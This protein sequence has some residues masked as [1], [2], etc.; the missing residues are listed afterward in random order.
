MA[1]TIRVLE[2]ALVEEREQAPQPVTELPLCE[3]FDGNNRRFMPRVSGAF[4]ARSQSGD[5]IEGID[6]SFGG[7][8]CVAEEPVWPGNPLAAELYLEGANVAVPVIGR[9]VELVS[10]RGRIAMR[11]RFTEVDAGSRRA[12]ANWMADAVGHHR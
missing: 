9:V 7:M 2:E 3:P 11:V 5:P 1:S 12:I 10:H 8:L 6:L 4:A